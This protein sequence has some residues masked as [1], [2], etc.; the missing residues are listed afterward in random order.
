MSLH[1]SREG[2]RL[3]KYYRRRYPQ[4]RRSESDINNKKK[5][6]KLKVKML[7]TV[8]LGFLLLAG[9]SWADFIPIYEGQYV[10]VTRTINP[11]TSFN[12]GPFTVTGPVSPSTGTSFSFFTFCIEYTE[13]LG[14]GGKYYV[15]DISHNVIGGGKGDNPDTQPAGA[16]S[17]TAAKLYSDWLGQSDTDKQNL[18]RN[19][20]YQQAIWFAE[21][22]Y[23]ITAA[24]NPDAWNLWLG[25]KDANDYYGV[26]ALNL[27]F[28]PY[29]DSLGNN[30]SLLVKDPVPEPVSMLLF[31]TGLV[32]IGG[33]F[34]RKFKK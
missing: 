31:G 34:R 24:A 6:T 10:Q 14:L 22:E 28:G 33:Y 8:I 7:F 1:Q 16:L 2:D 29:A 20:A 21:G 13:Y 27:K 12:G 15:D 32:G 5:G 25:A 11:S 30:Q 26:Y 18:N 3:K 4:N 19:I 17:W 9:N 23:T